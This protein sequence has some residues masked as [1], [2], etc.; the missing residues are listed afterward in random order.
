LKYSHGNP[1]FSFELFSKKSKET[2]LKPTYNPL[3]TLS[4]HSY[5]IL[6]YIA[7][8]SKM[9]NQMRKFW[10]KYEKQNFVIWIKINGGFQTLI[11]RLG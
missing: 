7:L 5:K 3:Y 2:A 4:Y 6:V 1:L 8:L 11:G 9:F 10:R